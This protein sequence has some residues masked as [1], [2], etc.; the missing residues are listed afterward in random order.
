MDGYFE[1]NQ[2]QIGR[3]DDSKYDTMYT[4]KVGSDSIAVKLTQ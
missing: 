2:A 4:D 3:R 1:K